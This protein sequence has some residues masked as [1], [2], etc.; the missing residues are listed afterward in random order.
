M[1]AD[2][3]VKNLCLYAWVGED[4]HG[5]GE[6]GLK[7]AICPAGMI[8]MVA[9]R[10]DKME[11]DY[12]VKQMEQYAAIYGMKRKLVKF[13]FAEVVAETAA[14]KEKPVQ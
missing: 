4:E 2:H 13:V 11:Q 1:M 5:S 6:I 12:I 14:G 9:I 8:P 7:Q 10:R 3:D